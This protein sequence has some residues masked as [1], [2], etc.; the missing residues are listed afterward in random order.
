MAQEQPLLLQVITRLI[1]GGAQLTVLGLCENLRNYFDV[2]VICGP[3]EGPEGSLRREAEA[4]VPVVVVPH[5]HRQ[6]SVI[7]DIR[8]LGR[9]ARVFRDTSPAI[10][11][12]HSSKA[13]ILGRMAAPRS[14]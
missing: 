7:S 13:G 2:R 4:M 9:L 10:I 3:D 14:A 11:H 1:V 6:V 5:L 12:T 8:A